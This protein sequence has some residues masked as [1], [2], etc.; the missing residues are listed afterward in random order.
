MIRIDWQSNWSSHFGGVH[1]DYYRMLYEKTGER[2]F[3]D[4][5]YWAWWHQWFEKEVNGKFIRIQLK[6]T[7]KVTATEHD[8]LFNPVSQIE[9]ENESDAI[10][11]KLRCP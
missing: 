5:S 6:A 1:S 8:R 4:A 9:F 10:L 3:L 2:P 7:W 11:F